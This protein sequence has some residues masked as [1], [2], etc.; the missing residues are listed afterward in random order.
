MVSVGVDVPRLGCMVVGGQPKNTAEYIQSTSRVGRR[1]PGLVVTVYNWARPRDLSHYETF[2]HYHATFYRQVEALSVTPFAPRARNRGLTALLVALVR[3]A[4]QDWNANTAAGHVDLSAAEIDGAV[5]VI[6]RRAAGV[7]AAAQ[8]A[9]DVAAELRSRRDQWGGAQAV[10]HRELVYRRRRGAG[11]AVGLL[12]AP[13][14]EPWDEWT[15]LT[16][17]R[18]VEPGINLLLA[19]A[20]LGDAT[21]PAFEPPPDDATGDEDDEEGES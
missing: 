18:D 2:A 3:H 12:K 5:E 21:A 1:S 16:S 9:S 6:R 19:E 13:S 10:P 7:T 17:L 4:R 14:M 15:V 20:D 11:T 8:V